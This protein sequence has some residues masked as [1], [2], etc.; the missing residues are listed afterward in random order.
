ML[1][2]DP[3]IESW[4]RRGPG[5]M[6]QLV[7]TLGKSD[8]LSSVPET[9]MEKKELN[10]QFVLGSSHVWACVHVDAQT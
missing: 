3:Y 8:E 2:M 10:T 1:V 7:K 9:H 5:E 6:V 4:L